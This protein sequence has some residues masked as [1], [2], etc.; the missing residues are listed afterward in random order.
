MLQKE[1]EAHKQR[2]FKEREYEEMDRVLDGLGFWVEE[3]L[4]IICLN[5]GGRNDLLPQGNV[6]LSDMDKISVV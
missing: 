4:L 1:R 2:K 6:D 5:N 3:R